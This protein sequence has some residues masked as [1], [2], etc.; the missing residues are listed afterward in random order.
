MQ[1]EGGQRVKTKTQEGALFTTVE[2]HGSEDLWALEEQPEGVGDGWQAVC[3]LE[4]SQE[5]FLFLPSDISN[6]N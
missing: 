4:S 1:G 2:I 6:H 3:L 5:I